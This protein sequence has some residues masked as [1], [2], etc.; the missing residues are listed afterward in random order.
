MQRRSSSNCVIFCEKKRRSVKELLEKQSLAPTD[1]LKKL[2]KQAMGSSTT[3][4]V[5]P[6][7]PSY[8]LRRTTR[9][10]LIRI[11]SRIRTHV[12]FFSFLPK[13]LSRYLLPST[14]SLKRRKESFNLHKILTPEQLPVPL[15]PETPHTHR[16]KIRLKGLEGPLETEPGINPSPQR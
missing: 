9:D 15:H 3:N 6:T 2:I 16:K 11:N 8:L 1:S 13:P 4:H 7:K 10:L 12:R 14:K 5:E